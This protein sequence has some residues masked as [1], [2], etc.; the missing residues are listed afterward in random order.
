MVTN[1]RVIKVGDEFIPQFRH[2]NGE[3]VGQWSPFPSKEKQKQYIS[4]DNYEEAKEK[5]IESSKS[6]F[7][8]MVG[9]FTIVNGEIIDIKEYKI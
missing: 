1:Y 5:C 4:Y 9:E 6:D 3:R 2:N 7:V 8:K